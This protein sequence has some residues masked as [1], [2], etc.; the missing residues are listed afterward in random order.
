MFGTPPS[1]VGRRAAVSSA[2]SDSVRERGVRRGRA[3]AH[4]PAVPS[5]V[6][7]EVLMLS[8]IVPVTYGME[9]LK[10]VAYYDYGWSELAGPLS[11]MCLFTVVCMGIGINL[12]ERRAQ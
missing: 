2:D 12:V 3:G 6:Q 8:K 9:A 7:P 11:I 5:V 4:L 10:G 1:P